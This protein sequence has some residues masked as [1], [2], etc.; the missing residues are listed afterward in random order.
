MTTNDRTWLRDA[1]CTAHDPELFFPVGSSGP[2][3]YQTDKARQVCTTCPVQTSC[4]DW[5]LQVGADYGV[6]GGLSEE[7]RQ[8]LRRRRRRGSPAAQPTN[9]SAA[10][11][12]RAESRLRTT[13]AAD[14]LLQRQVST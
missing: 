6:W 1:A 12:L 4:L 2:A 11:T 14:S 3:A 10:R 9:S 13:R 7:D 8:A 5:A